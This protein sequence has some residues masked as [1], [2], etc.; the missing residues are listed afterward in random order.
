[1]ERNEEKE[2]MVAPATEEGVFAVIVTGLLGLFGG[3]LSYSLVCA[4][5]SACL[6]AGTCYSLSNSSWSCG[7]KNSITPA[8][9]RMLNTSAQVEALQVANRGICQPGMRQNVDALSGALECV[10]ARSYPSAL[11][12]EIEDPD[13]TNSDHRRWCGNWIDAGTQLTGSKKWAFFDEQAVADD[14]D[15][16]LLARGSARIGG[17]D[18]SKFRAACKSM[19]VSNSAAAASRLAFDHLHA[20]IHTITTVDDALR[21]LGVLSSHFCDTPVNIGLSYDAVGFYS[22]VDSGTRLGADPLREALYGVGQDHST[23]D[24]AAEFADLM[25][26]VASFD[27][28]TEAHAKQV[29]VGSVEGTWLEGQAT[30]AF[31]IYSNPYNPHLARFLRAFSQSSTLQA[32]AYLV[33]LAAYCSFSARSVVTGEFGSISATT[34]ASERIRSER[35]AASAFGRLRSTSI[36]ADRFVE[37]DHTHLRN[38]TAVTMSSLS[39]TSN[40]AGATRG[41]ARSACLAA[42]RVAFPDEFDRIDF[43]SLVSD[44][45]YDRLETM[46]SAIKTAA[47]ATL[48]DDLVGSLF[49]S[50]ANKALTISLLQQTQLR[51]AG[52][53]RATWAGVSHSFERPTLTSNDGALLMLLKQAKATFLDRLYKVVTQA[54]VC[55]HPPLFNALERNAYL[56]VASGFSCAMLLPGMLV[57]PFAD[58]RYDDASLYSRIGYVI[59]HEFLHVT[60]FTDLWDMSYAGTIMSDYESSTYREGIADLGGLAS[61]MRLGVV[62]NAS[63]CAHVSQLWCGR[64]GW[65]GGGGSPGSHPATNER[66]DLACNF[67]RTHFS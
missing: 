32:R 46:T 3:A 9:W 63:L 28:V 4:E 39:A 38:A 58:E 20:Q 12:A 5:Q 10:R 22:S 27:A 14:V 35:P 19:V 49:S 43:E 2:R 1:M 26:V 24:H 48:N 67:L 34:L 54:S 31:R 50:T 16:V 57:P 55:Q 44:R 15:D 37:L 65:L 23:R 29:L 62:D 30:S 6:K 45:L 8:G 61:I 42:A 17:S 59:A 13:S 56:L 51:I 47:E 60:A 7:F 53:P 64:V 33:G 52:A 11:M 36:E 66:G 25:E 18:L 21:A 40:A 41:N